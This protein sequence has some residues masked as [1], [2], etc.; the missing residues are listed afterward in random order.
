VIAALEA[1]RHPKS[2]LFRKLSGRFRRTALKS[3]GNFFLHAEAAT[4][5]AD[6]RPIGWRIIDDWEIR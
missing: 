2:G 3:A 5:V 1:L 4:F 6:S